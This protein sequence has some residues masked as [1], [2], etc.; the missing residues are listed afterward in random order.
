MSGGTNS[1]GVNFVATYGGSGLTIG[2]ELFNF[3]T[4]LVEVAIN[5][6]VLSIANYIYISGSFTVLQKPDRPS[7]PL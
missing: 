2:N 4:P 3:T 5:D 6:A 7:P 1:V